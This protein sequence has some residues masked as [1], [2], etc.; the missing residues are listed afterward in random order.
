MKRGLVVC[1]SGNPKVYL[2][3]LSLYQNENGVGI[4]LYVRYLHVVNHLI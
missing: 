4:I 1:D 2:L 3:E